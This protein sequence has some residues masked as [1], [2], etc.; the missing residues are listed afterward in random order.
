M[1]MATR[2]AIVLLAG[3]V[4]WPAAGQMLG[5]TWETDIVLTKD[6]LAVMRTALERQVHGRAVGTIAA[7]QNPGS[8]HFGT[9]Q[10]LGEFSRSGR[11]C[12]RIDYTIAAA[13]PSMRAEHFVFDVCLQPDGSWKFA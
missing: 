11:R 7:W 3:L 9:L 1:S 10:L 2:I 6:D 8:G 5:P 12:E 4:P 13:T